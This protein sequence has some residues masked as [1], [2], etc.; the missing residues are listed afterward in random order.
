MI[1]ETNRNK[2]KIPCDSN[3]LVDTLMNH[4]QSYL[5]LNKNLVVYVAIMKDID[6]YDV[7]I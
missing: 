7:D 1:Q 4:N 5:F 6:M 2:V 3:M